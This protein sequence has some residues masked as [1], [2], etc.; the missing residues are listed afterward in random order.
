MST[1]GSASSHLPSM[2]DMREIHETVRNIHLELKAMRMDIKATNFKGL[3]DTSSV[4]GASASRP[5]QPTYARK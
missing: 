2:T 1:S 4:D 5:P 3:S